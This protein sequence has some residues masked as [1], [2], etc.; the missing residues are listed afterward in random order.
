[1]FTKFLKSSLV[2]SSIIACSSVFATT[3]SPQ[4]IQ[5]LVAFEPNTALYGWGFLGNHANARAQLLFPLLKNSQSLFYAAFEGK[6]ANSANGWTLAAGPGYRQIV[7]DKIFGGYLQINANRSPGNYTFTTLNPGLEC[8]TNNWDMRLNGY[9]ALQNKNWLAKT[10]W[11]DKFGITKYINYT[12]QPHTKYNHYIELF[13]EPGSGVDAEVGRI[14]PNIPKLKAFVGGYA[15]KTKDFGSIT[16]GTAR[17]TYQLNNHTALEARESYD[18]DRHN[19]AVIGIRVSLG[20][21][22]EHEKQQLGIAGRITD[23]IEHYFAT[24]AA[25]YSV[26]IKNQYVDDGNSYL[27]QDHIWF[28]NHP[29]VTYKQ[30]AQASLITETGEDGTYFHPYSTITPEIINQISSDPNGGEYANL[31]FLGPGSYNL[32]NFTSFKLAVPNSYNIY[33]YTDN[34][35]RYADGSDRPKINGF[36]LLNGG[37]NQLESFILYSPSEAPSDDAISIAGENENHLKNININNIDIG[38]PEFY[39]LYPKGIFILNADDVTITNSAIYS[40]N[41]YSLA[42]IKSSVTLDNNYFNAAFTETEGFGLMA[43]SSTINLLNNNFIQSIKT[44]NSTATAILLNGQS[45]LNIIGSNNTI[46]A[47]SENSAI[48]STSCGITADNSVINIFGN[49]NSINASI[50]NTQKANSLTATGIT[51]SNQSNLN[52]FGNSNSIVAVSYDPVEYG[53]ADTILN[54]SYGIL[55]ADSNI[56]IKGDH[57]T[58]AAAAYTN[59]YSPPALLAANIITTQFTNASG[60][61]LVNTILNI[62]GSF[63]TI[64]AAPYHPIT[65]SGQEIGY[66]DSVGINAENSNILISGNSNNILSQSL[67]NELNQSSPPKRGSILL[68]NTNLFISGDSNL[69]QALGGNALGTFGIYSL[70]TGSAP[71]Q[72]Y[73]V[74]ILGSNNTINVDANIYGSNQTLYGI[75]TGS[76]VDLNINNAAFNVGVNSLAT[77][78]FSIYAFDPSYSF[79]QVNDSTFNTKGTALDWAIY[80]SSGFSLT[81][82]RKLAEQSGSIFETGHSVNTVIPI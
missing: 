61:K 17:L 21:F 72:N 22:N 80:T 44:T 33:G 30:T 79:Y 69:I 82:Y 28:F 47:I 20:G 35:L 55:S 70:Y 5:Q 3:A 74:K 41:L 67:G 39:G 18:N 34:F 48:N 38:T 42:T 15:F 78:A 24:N 19:M 4:S 10:D 57:N 2:T 6:I 11:A 31:Y 65:G 68:N 16:G 7:N 36:L 13:E 12:I 81:D 75:Y 63:N 60:M 58:I 52:I 64:A 37:N 56:L 77:N 50:Y 23:P 32:N 71:V 53:L 54:Y 49:N 26:P 43:L 29:E 76:Y 8:F 40:A 51:L 25:G 62:E 45:T 9:I 27:Q 1:M 73:F 14:I 59:Q 66:V 46:S